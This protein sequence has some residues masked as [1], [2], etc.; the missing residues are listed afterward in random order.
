MILSTHAIVGA[1]AAQFFPGAPA[2][3]FG[4]AVASHYL[5]DL[6]PHREYTVNFFEKVQLGR[7]EISTVNFKNWNWADTIKV[8][9]DIALGLAVAIFLLGHLGWLVLTLGILGGILPDTLRFFKPLRKAEILHAKVHYHK[10]WNIQSVFIFFP[11]ILLDLA[12]VL[13]FWN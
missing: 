13:A 12:I 1:A 6:I 2:L 9:L 10:K 8:S 3:T 7:H 5:V 4:A 11:E